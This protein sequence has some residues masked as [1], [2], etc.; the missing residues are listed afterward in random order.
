MVAPV[1]RVFGQEALHSR[2]MHETALRQIAVAQLLL[3]RRAQ[4]RAQPRTDWHGKAMLRAL[5]QVGRQMTREQLAQ[6]MF[7]ALPARPQCKRQRAHV[8]DDAIIE[9][10]RARFEPISH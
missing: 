8:F 5:E 9:K 7:A 3:E 4:F 6:Q 1:R 10:R 2:R